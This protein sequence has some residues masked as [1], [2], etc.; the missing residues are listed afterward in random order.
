MP[1]TITS[2]KDNFH[3]SC[4]LNSLNPVLIYTK[5]LHHVLFLKNNHN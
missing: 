2:L 1:N 5:R 3:L 4:T